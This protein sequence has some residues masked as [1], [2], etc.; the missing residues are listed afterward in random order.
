MKTVTISEPECN[1]RQINFRPRNI[2]QDKEGYFRNIKG[3]MHQE[4]MAYI[5]VCIHIYTDILCNQILKYIK[6]KLTDERGNR[7]F[8]NYIWRFQYC[9]LKNLIEL[10]AWCTH[11]CTGGDRPAHPNWGQ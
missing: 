8:N 10:E 6:A 5:Y 9:T 7:K 1:S 2:P 4:D 3:S 11:L